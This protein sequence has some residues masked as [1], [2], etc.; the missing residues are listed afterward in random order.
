MLPHSSLVRLAILSLEPPWMLVVNY[1][2]IPKKLALNALDACGFG[3]KDG[4][5]R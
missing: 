1:K 4:H 3:L 5:I 2:S